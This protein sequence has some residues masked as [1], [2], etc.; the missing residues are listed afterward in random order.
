M[1]VLI[2]WGLLNSVVSVCREASLVVLG[3]SASDEWF[4]AAPIAVGAVAPPMFLALVRVLE[5][6]AEAPSWPH[7][8]RGSVRH[9]STLDH[10]HDVW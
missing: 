2:R 6:V 8:L 10:F 3:K 5:E 4:S 1:V 7:V 9:A